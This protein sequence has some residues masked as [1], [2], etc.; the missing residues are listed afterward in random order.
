MMLRPT[1]LPNQGKILLIASDRKPK[2]LAGVK[3]NIFLLKGNTQARE[4]LVKLLKFL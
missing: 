1:E 2:K 4:G 3:G